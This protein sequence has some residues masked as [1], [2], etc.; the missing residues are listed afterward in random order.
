VSA[1]LAAASSCYNNR[2]FGEADHL[3]ARIL[4]KDPRHARALHLSGLIALGVGNTS[5]AQDRLSRSAAYEPTPDV[6]VDLAGTLIL[7]G[8]H[9]QAV[10]CCMQALA[11]APGHAGAYYNLGTALNR[12][13]DFEPAIPVLREAVR[14][15]PDYLPARANL[16]QALRGAGE[17][18][19][20]RGELE[21]VLERDPAHSNALFN[22]ASVH[23]ELGDYG[24]SDELF[25]RAIATAPGDHRI[26][27]DYS[28]AL[29][30]RGE[31]ARGWELHEARWEAHRLA[32]RLDYSQPAWKGE[33]LAGK[34]LLVWGEQGLGDEIMFASILPEVL[35]EVSSA[36][37]V[38]DPKLAGLFARSFAR[39]RVVSR[40]GEEHAAVRADTFDYQVP[41]ASLALHRR[42]GT[43]GF[44][45]H[46]GYLRADPERIEKWSRRLATL[47]G[48]MKV[49]IAWRGGLP[50]T[51]E[52]LR[53]I[54]LEQW[55]PVLE[56]PGA[57]FVSLQH[58]DCSEE[59]AALRSSRGVEITHWQ[60][61]IDDY[62]ET[63]ALVCSLDLV[64]SVTTAL[65]HLA[66]ALDRP[67]WAL[68]PA[69]PGWRYLREGD[70]MPWYPSVR[71]LR[72]ERVGEWGSVVSRAAG[73]LRDLAARRA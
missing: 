48:G 43:G 68:V 32:D 72:Q 58:T 60:D 19:A 7:N 12:L 66:G 53:S 62:E 44:P 10:R 64:V 3:C 4:D 35:V 8:S 61:A 54:P 38:C 40:G 45:R 18:D 23:H 14:L 73:E 51:R 52:R 33:A 57:A 41:I 39:A 59:I 65:V 20:A 29:L 16:G 49:G 69:I 36:C 34:R 2:Q 11:V 15:K 22:L 47:G 31:F 28:L 5:A 55:L 25:G 42:R 27:Y 70:H 63:A 9:E 17:L 67:A 37:V 24:R 56:I 21:R 71:L 6:L 50:A 46:S 30:S 13:N 1:L 26:R